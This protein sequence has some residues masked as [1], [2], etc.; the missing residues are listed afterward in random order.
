MKEGG[1]FEVGNQVLISSHRKLLFIEVMRLVPACRESRN[2]TPQ[3]LTETL[4]IFEKTGQFPNS[5]RP[6]QR[7][8]SNA[9]SGILSTTRNVIVAAAMR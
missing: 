7:N 5:R 6:G 9:V 8:G 2:F 3:W 4:R 1:P